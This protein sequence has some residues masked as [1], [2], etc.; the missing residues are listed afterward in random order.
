M[1]S[2]FDSSATIAGWFSTNWISV[3]SLAITILSV[4]LAI[5]FYYK[6]KKIKKPLYALRSLNLVRD[7]ASRVAPLEIRYSGQKVE[8]VTV[9]TVAFWNGGNETMNGS[10]V[11][12]TDPISFRVKNDFRILEAIV[13]SMQDASNKIDLTRSRDE[14][15]VRLDFEYL[16][17]NQVAVL[18][19][20]HTGKSSNDITISGTVKGAGKPERALASR[21][22]VILFSRPQVIAFFGFL[23]IAEVFFIA[24]GIN[25]NS[26]IGNPIPQLVN[27]PS[28][29]LLTVFGSFLGSFFVGYLFQKR[30]PK[31]FKEFEAFDKAD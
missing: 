21:N 17:R 16:D 10:D 24:T 3:V 8:N 4:I 23:A 28:I 27:S 15:S 30:I 11:A 25:P 5:S 12:T 2:P 26:P 31:G 9:T 18:Q 1:G 20:I 22:E 29:S 13:V 6:S 14:R 19:V 7:F